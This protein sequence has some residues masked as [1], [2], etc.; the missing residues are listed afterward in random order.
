MNDFTLRALELHVDEAIASVPANASRKRRMREEMLAHLLDL[1]DQE[2][3]RLGDDTQA[4]EAAVHRFGGLAELRSE[5]H[6]S[7]PYGERL[8][9]HILGKKENIMWRLF[10][11]A[12]CVAVLVGL[13]FIMPAVAQLL[14]DAGWVEA[15]ELHPYSSGL[16]LTLQITLLILGCALSLGGVWS[17]FHGIKRFRL[18]RS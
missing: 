10:M 7:V 5:L 16:M 15:G 17:V 18:Q 11:I 4:L 13:G 1:F 6:D 12:G 2:H 14:R 8:V 9:F 3:A